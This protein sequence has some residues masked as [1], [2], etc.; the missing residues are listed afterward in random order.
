MLAQMNLVFRA[1]VALATVYAA[2]CA[3]LALGGPAIA[4]NDTFVDTF[5]R[6][7]LTANLTPRQLAVTDAIDEGRAL[8]SLVVQG[9]ITDAYDCIPELRTMCHDVLTG[10]TDTE[11]TFI[12]EY[13]EWIEG[14]DAFK[15][16]WVGLQMTEAAKRGF[17]LFTDAELRSGR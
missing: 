12:G 13:G 9:L 5:V 10:H 17:N 11:N 8:E 6:A 15:S 2:F 1:L 7:S 16:E 14:D 3:A 4:F